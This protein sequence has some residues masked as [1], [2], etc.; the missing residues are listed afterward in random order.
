MLRIT[1]PNRCIKEI[2]YILNYYLKGVL[3]VNFELKFQSNH[4][5]FLF[6]ND[7]NNFIIKNHF[8][9]SDDTSLLYSLDK[10]PSNVDKGTVDINNRSF[11]LVGIYGA[12]HYDETLNTLDLDILSSGFF[13]LSRWEE[14][15]IQERD[16]HSRF[17]SSEALAVK[18]D[19]IHKAVVNEYIELLWS[20]LLSIGISSTRKLQSYSIVPTHDVDVPY[21]WKSPFKAI[22]HLLGNLYHRKLSDFFRGLGFLLK[23]QDPYN[24]FD[25]LMSKA[26]EANV[27]AHF[28]FMSGGNTV[29][30]NRYSI[31]ETGIKDLIKEIVKRKH[32][33]GIHPSYNTYNNS[34]LFRQEK[35]DLE[36]NSNLSIKG[37]RQHYLR[38]EN[39]T[40]YRIWE[41]NNMSYD[42]TLGYAEH[43][44]FRCGICFPFPVFDI[45]KREPL[46]LIERPLIAMEA[47]LVVYNQLSVEDAITKV[48]ELKAEVKK[49]KGEFIFLW[50]NSSFNNNLYRGYMSLLDEMYA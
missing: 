25:L 33:I 31:E 38:F 41:D 2:E 10:I 13:M 43:S 30:D 23:G 44:G 11:E 37:G 17:K 20:L 34:A 36:L 48:R 22:R 6:S 4:H 14:S 1:A 21:L 9:S 39:P 47:T 29:Y 16:K 27:S 15:I 26:E 46:L 35:L 40:T 3:G 7:E 24:T 8:F 5:D 28:Y 42:S 19:F 32:N 45:F 18:H 12:V 49:Y 50:H